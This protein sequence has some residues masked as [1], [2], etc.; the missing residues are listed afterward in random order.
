[1]ATREGHAFLAEEQSGLNGLLK[2]VSIAFDRILMYEEV[3]RSRQLNKN[4]I[5][6]INEGLQLV[7]SAGDIVLINRAFAQ[8]TQMQSALNTQLTAKKVWLSHFESFSKEPDDLRAFLK[9]Q[10]RKASSIHA[11]Y[12]TLFQQN[13]KHSSKYML[14]AYLKVLKN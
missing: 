6:T 9:R 5:E 1:M 2:R 10:L 14:H 13:R 4:I 3:E 7:S 12:V 8:M 11:N